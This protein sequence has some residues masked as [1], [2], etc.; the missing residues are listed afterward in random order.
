MGTRTNQ[1]NQSDHVLLRR[2]VKGRMA[3]G[4]AGGL[5]AHFN[6]DV[7]LVRLAF[8]ALTVLGGAGV[9]LYAAAWLLV[10][11]EGSDTAIA[12]GFGHHASWHQA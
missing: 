10:P 7:T 1:D 5:A 4:V 2:S 11:E 12:D 3:G 8:V 6:L 9:P